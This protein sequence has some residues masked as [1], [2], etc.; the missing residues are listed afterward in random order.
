MIG[1]LIIFLA[2]QN[3][4]WSYPRGESMCLNEERSTS[5]DITT[6]ESETSHD[7]TTG[8]SETSHGIL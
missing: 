5:H 1:L 4:P 3:V 7:S 6:G 2:V 8:E